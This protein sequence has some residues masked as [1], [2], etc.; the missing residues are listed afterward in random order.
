MRFVL[1]FL[2][3][4][5]LSE[6]GHAQSF[7]ATDAFG[8]DLLGPVELAMAPGQP[9]RV[10][11]VEQGV[12]RP[13]FASR[14]QTLRLGDAAATTFLDLSDRTLKGGEAGFL[15]LAFHP[16]YAD[17]G[18]VFASYTA[19]SPLRSVI[20]EFT[21]SASDPLRA[22]PA[23]ERVLLEVPQPEGNHNAGQITFG[24]DGYLYISLGDGGGG[25][26]PE[27][28]GQD[29]TTLLGAILRIDVDTVPEGQPYGIPD[30]NPFALTDGPD[31]D[32]I[33][34]Y[35]FRNPW[36]F[37]F[38]GQGGDLWVMDVGQDAWEEVNRVE[39]GKNYGWNAVEG[40]ECFLVGCDLSA[41]EMPFFSYSH[42][43]AT[44]GFSISGGMVYR[45]TALPSLQG[46][47][48]YADYVTRRVWALDASGSEPDTT[49]L[50][51]LSSGGI[52]AGISAVREGPFGEAY[53]LVHSFNGPTRV[54]R[55]E[56]VPVSEEEDPSSANST[57]LLTGPNPFRETTEVTVRLSSG[58]LARVTL[59]DALGRELETL[60]EG[61]L[62]PG[63]DQSIVVP[64]AARPP[65]VYAVFLQDDDVDAR[66]CWPCDCRAGATCS[67]PCVESVEW[68]P[69]GVRRR[70]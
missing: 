47:V 58:G 67:R 27:Q 15:G 24:P 57:V 21:R 25:G 34:A 37:A 40:P 29:T 50:V 2:L 20:S 54:L 55:L 39:V 35:G 23:S 42:S 31:R 48:L 7:V 45:G 62:A 36:R 65:G 69:C 33:Y 52:N 51:T 59:H 60:F 16:G 17:N 30:T 56:Q 43:N 11:L 9:D 5:A 38:D 53:L 4:F 13:G 18:R 8:F 61:A 12:V 3:C 46:Q 66:L 26:D 6:G 28:N 70:Y 22:D 68:S 32:E 63:V 64:G 10:Y 49:H 44:G 19:S 1:S 41:F 14:V